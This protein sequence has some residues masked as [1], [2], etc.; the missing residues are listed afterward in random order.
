MLRVISQ[1]CDCVYFLCP[2]SE[3]RSSRPA[4]AAMSSV[5]KVKEMR[6]ATVEAGDDD[7]GQSADD[8]DS[9]AKI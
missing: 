3:V 2:P 4:V 9:N 6:P 5:A 1:L 8:S 7:E